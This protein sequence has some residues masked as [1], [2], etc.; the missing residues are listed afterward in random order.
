MGTPPEGGSSFCRKPPPVLGPRPATP[1]ARLLGVWLGS[2]RSSAALGSAIA[3]GPSHGAQGGPA[4][5]CSI[6]AHAC[7]GAAASPSEGSAGRRANATLDVRVGKLR[8][9]RA[10]RV[11]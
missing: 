9:S 1:C 2:T 6:R 4:S 10:W 3:A 8:P 5:V 11:Q 7:G